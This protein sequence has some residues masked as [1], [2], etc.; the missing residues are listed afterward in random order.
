MKEEN[1]QIIRLNEFRTRKVFSIFPFTFIGDSLVKTNVWFKYITVEEEKIKVRYKDF[2][3]GWSY[4]YYWQEWQEE[5]K[6]I[7]MI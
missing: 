5:W 7:K 3:D 2:D 4:C 1:Y 6:F